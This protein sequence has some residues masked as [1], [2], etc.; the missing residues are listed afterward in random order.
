MAFQGESFNPDHG[1]EGGK[2]GGARI[3]CLGDKRAT[4]LQLTIPS[5]A[6][7]LPGSHGG[8]RHRQRREWCVF[9]LCFK[10]CHEKG[11]RGGA[12]KGLAGL[13]WCPAG[14]EGTST[15]FHH[16]CLAFINFC[17]FNLDAPACTLFTEPRTNICQFI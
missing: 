6:A 1:K 7:I 11:G 2:R 17:L 12:G 9:P 4:F 16:F 14:P 13:L 8:A 15:V 3:I 10:G 5:T